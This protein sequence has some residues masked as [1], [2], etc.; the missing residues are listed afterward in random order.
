MASIKIGKNRKVSVTM[1]NGAA[2]PIRDGW[3]HMAIRQGAVPEVIHYPSGEELW[4]KPWDG[5]VA[6]FNVADLADGETREMGGAMVMRGGDSYTVS[7]DGSV[8]TRYGAEMVVWTPSRA[9]G[10]QA[11]R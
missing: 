4:F 2:V 8:W 11:A 10:A 9:S 7:S 3:T 6:G 1:D 5:E